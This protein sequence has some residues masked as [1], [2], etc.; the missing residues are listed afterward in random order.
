M[1]RLKGVLDNDRR[2]E[3][4]RLSNRA[5]DSTLWTTGDTKVTTQLNGDGS[6]FVTIRRGREFI[7][8]DWSPEATLVKAPDGAPTLTIGALVPEYNHSE[9]A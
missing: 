5:I 9:E 6:G 7:N 2:S 3:V 8:L 1:A 4:S